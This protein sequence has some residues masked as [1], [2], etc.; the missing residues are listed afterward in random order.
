MVVAFVL[1]RKKFQHKYEQHNIIKY[2]KP[3][4]IKIIFN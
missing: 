4:I 3:I 1:F 2:N